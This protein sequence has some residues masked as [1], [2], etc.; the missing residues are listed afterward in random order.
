MN[1]DDTHVVVICL[2]DCCVDGCI[3]TNILLA[4]T[5]CIPWRLLTLVNQ[6]SYKYMI[7]KLKLPKCNTNIYIY[8][9]IYIW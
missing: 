8:I 5:G 4:T 2:F 1:S 3:K 7:T 9:Y 6:G